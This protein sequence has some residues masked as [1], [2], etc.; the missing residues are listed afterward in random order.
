MIVDTK[1]HQNII[2]KVPT[3]TP[4]LLNTH[5]LIS[6]LIFPRRKTQLQGVEKIRSRKAHKKKLT[7]FSH[8][9][10]FRFHIKHQQN[11]INS[12]PTISKKLQLPFHN[13]IHA[14]YL[15]LIYYLSIEVLL[16]VVYQG[17]LFY[18]HFV[19]LC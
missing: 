19:C 2:N 10:F 15:T 9:P 13:I 1:M 12:S 17:V 4:F 5:T 18:L 16:K 3:F 14:R 7:V 11:S 6:T 8:F